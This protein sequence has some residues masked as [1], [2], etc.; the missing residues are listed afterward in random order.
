M[1]PENPEIAI[2]LTSMANANISIYNSTGYYPL[3]L[4]LHVLYGFISVLSIIFNSTVTALLWRGMQIEHVYTFYDLLII[5]MAISDLSIGTL[6][7]ITPDFVIPANKYLYPSGT[8]GDIFCRIIFSEYLLFTFGFYSVAIIAFI[9]LERWV[10]I[11]KPIVYRRYCRSSNAKLIMPI[12]FLINMAFKINNVVNVH[13]DNN[14]M[15]PCKWYRVFPTANTYLYWFTASEIITFYV[16]LVIILCANI[17][18]ERWSKLRSPSRRKYALPRYRRRR[19]SKMVMAASAALIICWLPNEIYFTLRSFKLIP[20]SRI[21][22]RTV[23]VFV[24]LNSVLNPVIYV[25]SNRSY[26]NSIVDMVHRAS[27]Y[28]FMVNRKSS[29]ND[30]ACVTLDKSC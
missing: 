10:A 19:M 13:Y 15:P 28:T 18:I 2:N 14:T 9:S 4:F 3:P 5:N 26:R 25:A 11:A 7:L 30:L 6:T 12:I 20:R 29:S 24:I 1:N 22:H 16:P 17:N 27:L 21:F 23:K 8:V